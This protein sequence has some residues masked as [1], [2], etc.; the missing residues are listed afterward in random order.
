MAKDILQK[1]L[2]AGFIGNSVLNLT[3]VGVPQGG[4]ISPVLANL[5]LDG[6]EQKLREKYPKATVQSRRAKVNL[7]RWADDFII[8]GS[9]KEL[10]EHEVKPL[11]ETF[12]K[13]RG[14]ELSPEMEQL[15]SA[16][17]L[18]GHLESQTLLKV[19]L[20]GRVIR[21]GFP[22]NF[23][24]AFDLDPGRTPQAHLEGFAIAAFGLAAEHPVPLLDVMKVLLFYPSLWL[25][26]MPA[27]CPSP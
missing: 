21:I 15:S 1:W 5:T 24:V 10:L 3:E 8:T 18:A 20:P 13:E 23:D 27:A 4:P 25:L 11:V 9:S 12:L 16:F 7:I 17:Q 2:T 14:L 26:R 22:M 19:L 6:L